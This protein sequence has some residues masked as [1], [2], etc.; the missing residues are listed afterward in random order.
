MSVLPQKADGYRGDDHVRFRN[1]ISHGG[2]LTALGSVGAN[3]IS[4]HLALGT[5]RRKLFGTY[6]GGVP[7]PASASCVGSPPF[8]PPM[9]LAT[10]D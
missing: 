1:M 6:L 9:W 8:W 3:T 10:A 2:C 4:H 7:W 5:G